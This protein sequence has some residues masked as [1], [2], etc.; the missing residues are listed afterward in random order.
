M[1][2]G[3]LEAFLFP[4]QLPLAL[5]HGSPDSPSPPSQAGGNAA[6]CGGCRHEPC[7]ADCTLLAACLH[8]QVWGAGREV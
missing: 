7:P 2:G 8:R 3:Q 5:P 4:G 1:Q 6:Q